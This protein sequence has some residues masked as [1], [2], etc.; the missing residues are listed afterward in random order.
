MRTLQF[1]ALS[2]GLGLLG[3]ARA[4]SP[5]SSAAAPLT[6]PTQHAVSID[7]PHADGVFWVRGDSY[8]ARVDANGVLFC[9]LFAGAKAHTPI[10]FHTRGAGVGKAERDG[11]ILVFRHSATLVERWEPRS[12]GMEQSFVLSTP[13]PTP[14]FTV[15]VE[16]A[17]QLRRN[18]YDHGL[19]FVADGLGS[20][21]YGEGVVFDAAGRRAAVIPEFDRGVITLHV[22]AS[23]LAEAE[24]PVTLDPLVGN[25]V[26]STN[27]RNDLNPDIARNP[28]GA[29]GFIVI[30]E[31][32]LSAT[33]TDILGHQYL[34]DGTF[35]ARIAFDSTLD[36]CITPRICATLG[37]TGMLA[38]WD[39]EDGAKGI[40]ARR[41]ELQTGVFDPV[42]Q[43]IADGLTEDSRT[44][45]VGGGSVLGFNNHGQMAVFVRRGSAVNFSVRGISLQSSGIPLGPEFVIDSAPGCDPRPDIAPSAGNLL[46][47]AV[48]WQKKNALC[49]GGDVWWAVVNANGVLLPAAE[50]EAGGFAPRVFTSDRDTLITWEEQTGSFGADI[51][52]VLMQRALGGSTFTQ[53]GPKVMASAFEPGC[54][55]GATQIHAA[56]GFDGCRHSYV[57]MEDGRPHG[58]CVT[59]GPYLYSE[60]HAS[61]SATTNPCALPAMTRVPLG[62]SS[63]RYAVVWQELVGTHSEIRGAFYEGRAPGAGIATV[64]TGCGRV[65]TGIRADGLPTIGHRFSIELVNPVGA[66]VILI[67]QATAPIQL[68][69]GIPPCQLGVMPIVVSLASATFTTR[70][71]CNPFL[72]GGT[73]A[74]QGVDLNATNGCS[75]STFGV[76]LRVTDTLVVTFQ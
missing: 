70:L 19:V 12:L 18:G 46:H 47:W 63:V 45:D 69:A 20:V 29:G 73:L 25:F 2:V 6:A 76:P 21:T 64:P 65:R 41:Y 68:C 42:A 32:V 72:V 40:Q 1:L 3:A 58:A 39:N 56:I 26:V 43:V 36:R 52:A 22:P 16:V 10:Q 14:D 50:L 23:F 62:D 8:K 15:H 49:G 75:A 60:G 51:G 54:P 7:E 34:D 55:R 31:E 66:P 37:A 24:Y 35:V 9:P 44:P 5:A 30:F 57:Y 33:D 53:V 28:S 61:L 11:Q 27:T 13:P 48:A 38:V 17:T 4:Q 59:A 74:F 67:G 71:P